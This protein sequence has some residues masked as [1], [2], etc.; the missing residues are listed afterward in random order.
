MIILKTPFCKI[1]TQNVL[2]IPLIFFKLPLGTN[3]LTLKTLFFLVAEAYL[4][5][6]PRGLPPGWSGGKWRIGGL[7]RLAGSAEGRPPAEGTW[8]GRR[9]A[10][11]PGGSPCRAPLVGPGRRSPS[12]PEIPVWTILVDEGIFID[13][14]NFAL[15]IKLTGKKENRRTPRKNVIKHKN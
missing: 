11:C 4:L 15:L 3:R 7:C 6:F 1:L 8:R 14:H 10:R 9:R 13:A 2:I 12:P 5:A